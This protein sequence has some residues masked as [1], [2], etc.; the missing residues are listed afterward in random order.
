[1]V[2][3]RS[4]GPVPVVGIG[5]VTSPMTRSQYIMAG[6]T[7]VQV[8]TAT[9]VN[10]RT[11]TE[12]VD[13]L[14]HLQ[15]HGIADIAELVGAARPPAARCRFHSSVV[16]SIATELIRNHVVCR[17]R[18]ASARTGRICSEPVARSVRIAVPLC[19][20]ASRPALARRADPG[21]IL[22]EFRRELVNAPARAARTFWSPWSSC[23]ACR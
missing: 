22:L 9:F 20:V 3:R 19:A 16:S 18:L 14:E 11:A 1:M 12:I 2:Y 17:V 5:G 6:A 4:G 23:A 7:A 15:Q 8:G 13:G 10:P 21:R